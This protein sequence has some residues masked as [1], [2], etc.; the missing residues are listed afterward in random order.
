MK[1]SDVLTQKTTLRVSDVLTH[2]GQRCP[3]TCQI[4][5]N[6]AVPMRHFWIAN[7]VYQI[8]IQNITVAKLP[9]VCLTIKILSIIIY[10]VYTDLHSDLGV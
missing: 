5:V 4:G 2:P 8:I 6:P 3:D 7:T 1:V 10:P 9:I